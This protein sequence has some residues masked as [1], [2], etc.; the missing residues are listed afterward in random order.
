MAP[1]KNR[2]QT[3]M[4][5]RTTMVKL[6]EQGLSNRKIAKRLH[7]DRRACDR[8]LKRWKQSGSLAPKPR[9]GA[10]IKFTDKMWHLVNLEMKRGRLRFLPDIIE[11][12]KQDFNVK[13]SES[14][15]RVH[16]RKAEYVPYT[17]LK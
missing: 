4:Q 8:V 17:P 1:R 9:P 16:L 10:P 15:V 2:G 5:E 7:R 3:T 13:L 6:K 12:I 14:C 11:Y